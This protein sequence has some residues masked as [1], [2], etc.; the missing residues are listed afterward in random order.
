MPGMRPPLLNLLALLLLAAP[1][2]PLAGAVA[3]GPGPRGGPAMP[4]LA[5]DQC[6][7]DGRARTWIRFIPVHHQSDKPC[8]LILVLHGGGSTAE[9]MTTITEHGFEHL[10]EM[11]HGDAVILYPD[12]VETNWHDD[13]EGLDT[14]AV[15]Q[16][17]DDVAFLREAIR[18][19]GQETA[20]DPQL[21]FA[22]GLSSGGLMCYRL[23]REAPEI[24]AIAVVAGLLPMEAKALPWPHPVSTL[25]IA[26]TEDKLMPSRGGPLG[27][28]SNPRG[29]VLSLSDTT[30]FI[31]TQNALE[32]TPQE[33]TLAANTDAHDV[34][35]CRAQIYGLT[36]SAVAVYT[37]IGGGHTWPSGRQYLPEGLIGR[38]SH[39]INAC[40]VC[41]DFFLNHPHR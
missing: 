26:G 23:A 9:A 22:V 25:I 18:K 36:G 32:D 40:Q 19:T 5:L 13:R 2:R 34:T 10:A 39:A 37:I 30:H 27:S 7:I 3:D 8:P 35:S 1:C 24:A 12:A 6:V 41:W 20:I 16:H 38:T 4:G 17:V 14:A 21:I 11:P 31:L 29:E 15:V 33:L 28:E